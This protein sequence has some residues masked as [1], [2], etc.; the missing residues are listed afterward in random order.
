MKQ[1]DVMKLKRWHLYLIVT[2]CF[3]MAF[4]AIN[5]KYDRFYRVNGINND[6]RA[7]IE[8]LVNICTN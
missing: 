2:L 5:R 6:N 3:V 1:G 8:M 4:V 7:L